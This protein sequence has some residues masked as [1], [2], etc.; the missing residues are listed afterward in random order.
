MKRNWG[1][2]KS[3]QGD[4]ETGKSRRERKKEPQKIFPILTTLPARGFQVGGGEGLV[5]AVAPAGRGQRRGV[6][7]PGQGV[8]DHGGRGRGR[9]AL[10]E[11]CGVIVCLNPCAIG[12]KK[13]MLAYVP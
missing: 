2:A 12:D 1:S 4:L 8:H 13:K 11:V 3:D 6:A 9:A 7:G 10:L 5:R